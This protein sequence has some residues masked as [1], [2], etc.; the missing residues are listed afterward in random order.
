MKI[1][2][3]G[4][5]W[6]GCHLSNKLRHD[7]N[8]TLFEKNETL[9][10]ETSFFNQNRLHLGYHYARNSKTRELCKNTFDMFIK[11]Y[12][13]ITQEIPNNIYC[14]PNKNSL[15]DYQTYLKIFDGYIYKP[16]NHTFNN[17]DG[18]ISTDERYINFKKINNY[19]NNELK[20]LHIKKK[21]LS[22]DLKKY[23]KEFDLVINSTN[24]QIKDKKNSECF[25]ELTITLLY[26]KINPTDFGALTMVD[27]NLFSIYP[28]ESNTYTVTDVEHTPIKKF[29]TINSLEKFKKKISTSFIESKIQHIENKIISY[30]PEFL[31]EFKYKSYFLS[32]KSKI[33]DASDSRSPI[34]SKEN[35]IINCFT[36]KIQGIYIIENYIKN[37]INNRKHRISR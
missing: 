5:G 4:G 12:G 13:F 28:Y 3:I 20:N 10:T 2:I 31:L 25:Y 9:F 24:N 23:S 6:V 29:K 8:I 22:S 18:C 33:I 15:I 35:N 34:I 36:G 30:Y 37:E 26:D 16:Y 17:V 7:H 19:F 21:V 14:V 27:G 11:D 1:A 32:I